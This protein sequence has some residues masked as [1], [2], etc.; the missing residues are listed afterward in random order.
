MLYPDGQG[1]GPQPGED[2]RVRQA[3][4]TGQARV[5]DVAGGAEILVPV[6]LGGSS[7]TAETTPVI[8]V[9]VPEPGFFS[10]A[11]LRAY[12]AL[13]GLG[14]ALLVGALLIADRLGRSFVDPIRRLATYTQSL[15]TSRTLPPEPSGPPEVREL[16]A[17]MHR[18]VGRIEL[19]LER[20]R[21]AVSDLSH[22][23]RTPITALRL[24]IEGLAESDERAR[25]SDDLDQLAAD[26]RPR[27]Q[28]GAALRARGPGGGYAGHRPADRAGRS[29]GS[30]WPRT[31]AVS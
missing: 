12:L 18:L 16:T 2:D 17:T 27:R 29:S 31:R 5:D 14:L 1:V 9:F 7:T 6:S 11:T 21:E 13:T 10:D 22:R 3:R 4:S 30:R 23:L 25:L 19:L 24:R 20:E 26:G 28:R 15:G 8:R